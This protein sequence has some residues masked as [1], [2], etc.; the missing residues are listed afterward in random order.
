M[1][2]KIGLSSA[3][4]LASASSPHANHSTGLCACC[5]R[6]GEV[7]FARRFAIGGRLPLPVAAIVSG[8][9]PPVTGHPSGP[10]GG[11]LI[12][13]NELPVGH[14]RVLLRRGQRSVTE[15]LLARA[16]VGAGVQEMRGERMPQSVRRNSCTE[17]GRAN[18]A[19]EQ[20]PYAAHGDPLTTIVHEQ[21]VFL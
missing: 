12:H 13:R 17:R 20:S 2:R 3:R 5:R 6:Y 14:M 18:V 10:R 21:R 19:A 1:E 9:R 16:E 15:E 8:N 11:L 4:A 7:S